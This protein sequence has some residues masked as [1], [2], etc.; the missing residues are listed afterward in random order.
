MDVILLYPESSCYSFLNEV[1]E[2]SIIF[3]FSYEWLNDE[4]YANICPTYSEFYGELKFNNENRSSQYYHNVNDV[5][6]CVRT[7]DQRSFNFKFFNSD[8]EF[9]RKQQCIDF[10]RKHSQTI[11]FKCVAWLSSV[12][13]I[14]VSPMDSVTHPKSYRIMLPCNGESTQ[15]L[16][17]LILYL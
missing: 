6:N 2:N 5:P 11:N 15:P 3:N 14:Y 16:S 13:E 1:E 10:L 8:E 12:S 9:L 17:H 7:N 4:K